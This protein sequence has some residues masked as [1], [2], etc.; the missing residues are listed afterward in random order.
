[1][2]VKKQ[3]G[4][5]VEIFV[6]FLRIWYPPA[7]RLGQLEKMRG[8][9]R[10]IIDEHLKQAF[11][12]D[13]DPCFM[14]SRRD[15]ISA[16]GNKQ[17]SL[18]IDTLEEMRDSHRLTEQ[19]YQKLLELVASDQYSEAQQLFE[20]I[21]PTDQS[22]EKSELDPL[23]QVLAGEEFL[24]AGK[25]IEALELFDKM[26]AKDSSYAPAWHNRG[27]SL[28][29][30]GRYEEAIVSYDKAIEFI[31]NGHAAW[32]D[33]GISLYFLDRYE[34]AISSYDKA[35]EFKP[36]D[37]KVWF[38]RGISLDNLGRYEEAISS[39]DKAIEFKPDNHAAWFNRGV[40]LYFLGRYEEAIASYD[41]AI[42]FKPDYYTAWHHKGLG[43]FLM[44]NSAAA[45]HSWQQSFALIQQLSP[46][47]TNITESIQEF[48]TVLI[49][50]F[51]VNES[52]LSQVTPI[53]QAA[54]VLPELSIV[55]VNTLPQ[56]LEP[57]I[58]DHTADRWLELWQSLLGHETALEMPLR[59]MS[60]A[61]AY[62]KQPAQQK[63]LWLGL[64][65]EE[66]MILDRA[67]D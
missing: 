33:R 54:Q 67:L 62:K 52:V 47:P 35:I 24:A 60:T 34:E 38:N 2:E 25:H 3:R 40:S 21:I 10:Y 29:N 20:A 63:R 23:L 50:R 28:D 43:H 61:I 11:L 57:S 13:A 12:S 17:K 26:L 59:L 41:K 16:I 37:H 7:E 56:I 48:I 39:Y 9:S 14:S 66:R 45:L 51:T 15:F 44:G 53:Y 22:I 5:W 36:D 32:F 19:N 30:L 55:L 64:A 18:A 46:R 6:E 27:V 65:R 1:L 31:P 42:E 8:Q 58:S 4:Q 49:P